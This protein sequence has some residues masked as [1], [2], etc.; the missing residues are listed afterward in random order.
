MEL[1]P[2]VRFITGKTGIRTWPQI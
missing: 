2:R 1:L